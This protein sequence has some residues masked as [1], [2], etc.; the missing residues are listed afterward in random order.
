VFDE[1]LEEFYDMSV[2][3][4]G[5]PESWKG[6]DVGYRLR[7]EY[8]DKVKIGDLLQS[9]LE[10]PGVERLKGLII[11]AWSGSWEG[12]TSKEIVAQLAAAAERLPA[13]RAIF[14][15]E[16][17]YEECELSWINQSDMSPLLSAYPRLEV[18]QI[19]GG[20]EL[21]FSPIRHEGLQEL[22]IESG[23]LGR[24]TLRELFRCDF[25]N[26]ESLRLLLGEANYGFDGSVEDLQPLLSGQLFP[27]LK[28]LGLLNSEIENE[29]AAVV[30]NSP[31]VD[32]IEQL[33]LSLGNLD[34]E[35]V[36]SLLQL[37]SKTNLNQ[38]FLAHHYA[39]EA[40]I[41]EL[42]RTLPFEVVE[43]HRQEPDDEWRPI[44]HAE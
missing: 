24:S 17:I 14:M 27:K 20:N 7:E 10:Q 39:T 15:G 35:G 31:I 30:V 26:V 2:V 41:E 33:D 13:L 16:I 40:A 4:Y 23:G 3:D 29:I 11:G 38:L 32:R 36:R 44:L 12:G 21:S 22:V 25:P 34:N 9:L 19:R 18:L 1:P 5:G 43:E 42:K 8:D 37:K 28:Y 6:P